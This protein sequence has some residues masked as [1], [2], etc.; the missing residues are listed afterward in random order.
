M[1]KGFVVFDV[2]GTLIDSIKVDTECYLQTAR[3]VFGITGID[4]DWS[5]YRT[6]TDSGIFREIF[7]R[8]YGRAPGREDMERYVATFR[9][10][11]EERYAAEGA[12][13][14][15]IPGARAVL[16][17]LRA[18][19]EWA[20]GIATGGWRETALL[21]LRLAGID[22]SDIPLSS[23]W[24]AVLREDIVRDCI[25]KAAVKHGVKRF[26]AIV[27]VG[28]AS[29]DLRTARSLGIHFIGIGDPRAFG[30]DAVPVLEDFGGG[31]AFFRLLESLQKYNFQKPPAM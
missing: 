6:A 27:S 3:E 8:H 2:D 14:R 5:N 17:R 4:T 29:W 20:V 28:D 26:P 15:E 18:G 13:C 9:A 25:G 23:S 11:L 31:D 12:R 24:D 22:A 21:K 7:E 10:K 19:G 1:M 30:G 16:N